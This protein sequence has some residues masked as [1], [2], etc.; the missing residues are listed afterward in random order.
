MTHGNEA[1]ND[2]NEQTTTKRASEASAETAGAAPEAQQL[3]EEIAATRE[4]LG[5]TV[6][7]LADKAD[8]KARVRHQLGERKQQAT[9]LARRTRAQVQRRPV[10]LASGGGAMLAVVIAALRRRRN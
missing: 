9:G 3:R 10:L 1:Q 8:V 7:A 2:V 5:A 6:Q 4:D